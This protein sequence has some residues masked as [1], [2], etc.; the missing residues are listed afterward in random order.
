MKYYYIK[1]VKEEGLHIYACVG[2]QYKVSS[3]RRSK[4]GA[5]LLFTCI[6]FICSLKFCFVAMVV[7][8]SL[9][10]L[11]RTAVQTLYSQTNASD[12]GTVFV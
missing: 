7:S 9:L 8:C 1:E 12:K 3:Y 10:L 2:F 11:L 4:S 6:N 5:L